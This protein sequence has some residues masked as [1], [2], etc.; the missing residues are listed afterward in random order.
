[1][2]RRRSAAAAIL[3]SPFLLVACSSAGVPAPPGTSTSATHTSSP[4][5]TLDSRAQPAVTAYESF[6]ATAHQAQRHPVAQG[7]SWPTGADFTKY[8]FDPIR[9]SYEAYIW[10]LRA[11]GVEFRG[12][13]DTSHVSVKSINLGASPW[14]LV[15]L[16]DC[17]TGG[18]WN[19][20]VIKTGKKLSLAG[21]GSAPPPYLITAKI[22]YF[23]GHWGLQSNTADKTRTCTA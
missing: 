8:S 22:I 20:Y 5:P 21:N 12:T 6:Q 3:A 11:E 10:S 14:P 16:T 17:Q 18:D 15:T 7:Q 19:A 23:D 1:L 4:T 13:P 2:R 9:A